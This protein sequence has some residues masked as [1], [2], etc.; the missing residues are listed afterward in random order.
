[1][2]G[3]QSHGLEIFGHILLKTHLLPLIDIGRN[4]VA[5]VEQDGLL[6]RRLL[7]FDTAPGTTA[8]YLDGA[9]VSTPGSEKTASSSFRCGSD[10]E[11]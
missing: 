7:S 6:D 5:P 2:S 8:R 1:M 3:F 10:T 9:A 4:F 11:L